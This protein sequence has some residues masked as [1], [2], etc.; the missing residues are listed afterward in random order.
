MEKKQQLTIIGMKN[1][2]NILFFL[3][4][5]LLA[6][7]GIGPAGTSA[8]LEVSTNVLN[9]PMLRLEPQ[10]NPEGNQTGQLAVI[11][12][13]LFMFDAT[14]GKWLSIENTTLEFGRLGAGSAPSEIEFGGGDLQN[15]PRMPFDGTIIDI[16]IS[17]TDDDNSREIGLYINSIGIPNNTYYVHQ[18]G[19]F[20][21]DPITLEYHNKDYN[22]NFNAGDMISLAL[23]DNSVNDVE[24]LIVTLNV[25]WR[26]D[27]P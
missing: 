20:T 6:Q 21:L 24:D 4:L 26:K 1:L 17:A 22:L 18:D 3:P 9:R 8:G 16:S 11:D 23:L 2:L 5:S 12:N 25:R 14:R 19:V 7:V 15:G 10:S 27:N 13:I